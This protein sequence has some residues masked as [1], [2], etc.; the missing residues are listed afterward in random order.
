VAIT[1]LKQFSQTRTST[2]TPFSQSKMV[3]WNILSTSQYNVAL[4]PDV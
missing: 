1:S 4:A 2:N 3:T